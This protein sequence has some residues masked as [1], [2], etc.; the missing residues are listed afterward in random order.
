M[1]GKYQLELGLLFNH[2]AQTTAAFDLSRR[3]IYCKFCGCEVRSAARLKEL[4]VE[5]P[6]TGEPSPVYSFA[7]KRLP[8]NTY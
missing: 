2:K 8:E 1:G 5:L 4:R 6:S 3:V 7:H